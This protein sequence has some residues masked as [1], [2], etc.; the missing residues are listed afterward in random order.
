[1]VNKCAN[2][3]ATA[4]QHSSSCVLRL[5]LSACQCFH[6]WSWAGE[7]QLRPAGWQREQLIPAEPAWSSPR[8]RSSTVIGG[9]WGNLGRTLS[10]SLVF[11]SIWRAPPPALE[12]LTLL[13]RLF[14]FQV[15][16]FT[17]LSRTQQPSHNHLDISDMCLRSISRRLCLS[18]LLSP[19]WCHCVL[20]WSITILCPEYNEEYF[21]T[22]EQTKMTSPIN[23]FQ[24]L[25]F[26]IH[27]ILRRS[28]LNCQYMLLHLNVKLIMP[29]PASFVV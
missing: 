1:M 24:C 23:C 27:Y 20:T 15:C 28:L 16:L 19:H 21:T 12:G 22:Y 26:Y 2:I 11:C 17:S 4:A 9:P 13:Y 25:V 6:N 18:E 14:L 29:L 5:W 7:R 8:W 10:A 3:A